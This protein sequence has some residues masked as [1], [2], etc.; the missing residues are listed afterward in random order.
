MS[1]EVPAQ[2]PPE[3]VDPQQDLN[4]APQL[5]TPP[6]PVP[7]QTSGYQRRI[8]ELTAQ[9]RQAERLAAEA[10]NRLSQQ[11]L[12]LAARLA[13]PPA[14][15]PDITKQ[16]EAT[17]D[18]HVLELMRKAMEAQRAE[19]ER[20]FNARLEEQT[21]Q[22]HI[23]QGTMQLQQEAQ[24]AKVDPAIA[25]RAAELFRQAKANGSQA[26]YQEALRFAIG[27]NYLQQAARA[28][29]VQGVDHRQFNA[30]QPSFQLPNPVPQQAGRKGPPP[31]FES[32]PLAEQ[33]AIMERDGLDG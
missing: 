28:Q 26:T 5:Q 30:P 13:P 16:Y 6:A 4:A 24:A 21:R 14:P 22:L 27:D 10:T 31:N 18:P 11:T 3:P 17:V 12:E 25:A 23:Q 19:M 7:D 33:L 8:D 20:Q 29:N 2:L 15:P 1:D 32:L 9:A